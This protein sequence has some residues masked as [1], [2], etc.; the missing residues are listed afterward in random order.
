MESAG[1]E[2]A[3]PKTQ[4]YAHIYIYIE[5]EGGNEREEIETTDIYIRFEEST[6]FRGSVQ[7][8]ENAR[9][10]GFPSAQ[11]TKAHFEDY[12]VLGTIYIYMYHRFRGE[13][14]GLG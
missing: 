3:V 12:K 5:R 4:I 1:Q 6:L 14:R 9:I 13:Q 8:R 10:F 11:P 2:K 7:A